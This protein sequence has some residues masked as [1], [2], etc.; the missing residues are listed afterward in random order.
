MM[1]GLIIVFWRR[2]VK[3]TPSPLVGEFVGEDGRGLW[4]NED[5]AHENKVTER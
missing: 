5:I 3:V 1:Y 4:Y 2:S